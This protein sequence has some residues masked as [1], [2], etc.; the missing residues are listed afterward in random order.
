MTLKMKEPVN[1]W[2]HFIL[3]MAA[4][5]GLVFLI[6][7]SKNNLSKLVTMTIY[8]LSMI[9]LY[10]ASSLY[11]WVKT[12][13]QKE[14]I[15]KKVDHIAIYFLIAG[16][17][18]PVFYYGLDGAWR[19]AMLT[20]VWVLALTGM[21]LKIWFI[22]APRYVSS[23]FYVSLGWIALVP[24]LQLIKNLPMGSIILMAVGG[25]VYTMGAIIY[26]TKIFDFYPKRF[27]FHEVFHLFIAAGSIVHYLM[28]LIYIVPMT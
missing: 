18:T 19:W 13:P 26:A 12:T 25:V 15:L 10:G 7:L 6:V 11:H 9:V 14:L 21:A 23:A 5:V 8:G 24:F 20:A 16:S 3:F 28:V 2:T 4:I 17:Y 27:G 22:H 1:T